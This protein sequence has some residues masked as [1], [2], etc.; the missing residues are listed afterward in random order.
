M[1]STADEPAKKH[2][3]WALDRIEHADRAFEATRR[4]RERLDV[5]R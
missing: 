2:G 3:R 4:V 1:L 5:S